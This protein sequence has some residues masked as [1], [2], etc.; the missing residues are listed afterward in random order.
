[1]FYI[2]LSKDVILCEISPRTK[3][4][5]EAAEKLAAE[6]SGKRGSKCWKRKGKR[7]IE[8]ATLR[9]TSETEADGRRGKSGTG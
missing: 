2:Y 5:F 9:G 4:Q 8:C 7:R 3:N 6:D 1:M